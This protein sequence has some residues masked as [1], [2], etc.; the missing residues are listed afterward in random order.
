[1]RHICRLVFVLL[2]LAASCV[3]N[4][5]GAPC[6]TSAQCPTNQTCVAGKCALG[7]DG[8]GGGTGVDGGAGGGIG[9]AGGTGGSG[10]SGG[11][12][13]GAMGTEAD[14][15]DN[16]DNDSDGAFDCEDSDCANEE[17]R[18][19]NS[20]CDLAE[21]CANLVC[22][23]DLFA[24]STVECRAA[25]SGSC[26][27]AELCTGNSPDCPADEVIKAGDVCR[28][29]DPNDLC[30]MDEA[31][32]GVSA[33]CPTDGFMPMGTSCR[34]AADV[35]DVEEF[36]SGATATC[37]PDR[38]DST[39]SVCRTSDGRLCDVPE[40]CDGMSAAC[41]ADKILPAGQ[42]CRGITGACDF[43]EK[44]DGVSNQCP[45]DLNGCPITA[46]CQGGVCVPRKPNGQTCGDPG[47]CTSG[48]C[49][50]GVC[51]NSACGGTCKS[52]NSTTPGT[53][54]NFAANT[55]PQSEC[56][57]YNCSGAGVCFSSCSGGACSLNCKAGASCA[58]SSCFADSP[59]GKACSLACEC[60]SGACTTFYP[61][62]DGDT[63]GGTT[64][65]K[66]CGTVPRAGYS[67]NNSDCCDTDSRARPGQTGSYSDARIGCGGWDFNCDGTETR[68]YTS[69][70]ACVET[71]SCS[72]NNQRCTGG[73][74]WPGF[75]APA[76]GA[77]PSS[78]VTSCG[79]P[80]SS[81]GLLI[82]TGCTRCFPGTVTRAQFCR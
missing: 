67:P 11:S 49:T 50:D 28:T 40:K 44:C 10:G 55:D 64:A 19:G 42:S 8:V 62:G 68:Y 63:F 9:S 33:R 38:F 61:D 12:G 45:A 23:T 27:R 25:I 2:M 7:T 39:G 81:C 80:A 20:E 72:S 22:P 77:T 82:C 54:V 14:C 71:G 35:C 4:I 30:D 78:Y 3:P 56:A 75:I 57:A 69:T 52:C 29:A 46:F 51:C 36:C 48:F 37:P 79:T 13:G 70:L 24:A 60:A 26:D 31:C 1:M 76:C 18:P 34:R 66:H 32:D 47:Q 73:T 41:P 5:V 74:G 6:S 53:C 17:C 21:T 59:D 16:L 65:V 15:A 58:G 43:E